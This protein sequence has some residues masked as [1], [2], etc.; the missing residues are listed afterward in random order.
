[1]HNIFII[2]GPSGCGKGTIVEGL[3]SNSDLNL[4]WAKSYTTRPKRESDN[5]EQKYIFVTTD[6]F[7]VLENEGEILESNYYN[8]NWYGTSKSEIENNIE[9]HNIIKDIDVNGGM[10]YRKIFPNAKLIFIESSIDD[11]KSRLVKRGQNTEVEIS[12]RLDSAKKELE[13]AKDYDYIINNPEG[14]PEKAIQN[15]ADII[16]K[17]IRS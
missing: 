1:M 3:I 12:Q 6:K 14:Y 8:G 4:Y 11:I 13:M 17:Q 5:T 16:T 2:S 15:I 9:S 10:A 7:K